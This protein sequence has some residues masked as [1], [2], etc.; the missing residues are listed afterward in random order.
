[1]RAALAFAL[2]LS[3]V[4]CAPKA[5]PAPGTPAAIAQPSLQFAYDLQAFTDSLGAAQTAL[6]TAKTNGSITPATM[7]TINAKFIVP[8]A[9]LVK[10]CN[11]ILR[12]NTDWPTAKGQIIKALG[13]AAIV[14]V[15]ASVPQTA[16]VVIATSLA[17]YN[18]IAAELGAP[19]I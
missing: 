7:A 11:A 5:V 17:A 10:Q 15:S 13:A 9:T 12:A 19:T 14:N 6:E 8:A 1:M 18:A 3:L 16:Q 4:A 2:L